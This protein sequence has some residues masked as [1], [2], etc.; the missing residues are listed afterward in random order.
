MCQEPDFGDLVAAKAKH[1]DCVQVCSLSVYLSIHL[2]AHDFCLL[3]YDCAQIYLLHPSASSTT[4]PPPPWQVL[5]R[6][7]ARSA[8]SD[9]EGR[10]AE[11]Y[12]PKEAIQLRALLSSQT[13]HLRD[14]EKPEEFAR[15]TV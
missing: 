6:H 3:L 4:T 10:S 15:F 11:A 8:D 14:T 5:L 9:E 12:A 13:L 7:G 1:F 2:C